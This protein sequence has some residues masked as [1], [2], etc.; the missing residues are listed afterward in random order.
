MSKQEFPVRDYECYETEEERRFMKDN[1]MGLKKKVMSK[2]RKVRSYDQEM[3]PKLQEQIARIRDRKE[4]DAKRKAKE[5][6]QI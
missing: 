2:S 6:E 1:G 4:E 3:D 5:H